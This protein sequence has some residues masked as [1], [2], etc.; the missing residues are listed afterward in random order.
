MMHDAH[1]EHEIFSSVGN[2]IKN[3]EPFRYGVHPESLVV[4]ISESLIEKMIKEFTFKKH[5]KVYNHKECP[6]C[7]K[8]FYKEKY[9]NLKKEKFLL[10]KFPNEVSI[11]S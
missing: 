6:I 4:N 3:E 1:L 7:E 9:K 11:S 2:I 8:N 5:C 10:R